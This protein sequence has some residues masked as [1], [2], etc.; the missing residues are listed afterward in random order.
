MQMMAD[1]MGV[2]VFRPENVRY[3]GAIGAA[4]IAGIGLN[5]FCV[6]RIKDFVHIEKKFYPRPGYIATYNELYDVFKKIYPALKDL[7]AA[8]NA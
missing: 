4:F 1:I 6:D 7:F 8:L 2:P 5:L 3:A